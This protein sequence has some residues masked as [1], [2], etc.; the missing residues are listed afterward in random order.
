MKKVSDEDYKKIEELHS[1]MLA[2]YEQ[3][4]NT[5]NEIN[6]QI[7]DLVEEELTPVIDEY[8]ENVIELQNRVDKISEEIERIKPLPIRKREK[9][10]R[11]LDWSWLYS[12]V[13]YTELDHIEIDVPFEDI[14]IYDLP[15]QYPKEE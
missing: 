5:V 7:Y 9:E 12:S 15:S 13:Q 6:Y 11:I 4:K 3:Y 10:E 14:E 2:L 8:N 1:K